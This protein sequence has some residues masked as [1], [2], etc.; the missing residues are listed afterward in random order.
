MLVRLFFKFFKFCP[1]KGNVKL[2]LLFIYV[3]CAKDH[4]QTLYMQWQ[5]R[6]RKQYFRRSPTKCK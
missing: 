2:S 5:M 1:Q 6:Q 3:I 4:F